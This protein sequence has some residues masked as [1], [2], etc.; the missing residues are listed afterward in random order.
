MNDVRV[1]ETD[2]LIVYWNAKICKHSGNCVKGA[3]EVFDVKKRPW[4]NLKNASAE[5]IMSVIDTC[6]LGVLFYKRKEKIND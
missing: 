4:I 5:K 2:E 1:Y 6:P 3:S